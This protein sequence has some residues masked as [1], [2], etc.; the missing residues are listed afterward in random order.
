MTLDDSK[1][2]VN[3]EQLCDVEVKMGCVGQLVPMR[4]RNRGLSQGLLRRVYPQSSWQIKVSQEL[5][6]RAIKGC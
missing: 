2:P 4:A 5:E 1:A 3:D 6:R